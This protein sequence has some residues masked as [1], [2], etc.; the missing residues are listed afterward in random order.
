[1]D[2][3][4]LWVYLAK[5]NVVLRACRLFAFSQIG[6]QFYTYIQHK[7]FVMFQTIIILYEKKLKIGIMQ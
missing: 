6:K 2:W 4:C 3:L 1:M 5:V 7:R